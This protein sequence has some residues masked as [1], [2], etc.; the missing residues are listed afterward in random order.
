[1]AIAWGFLRWIKVSFFP[2]CFFGFGSCFSFTFC[3]FYLVMK[4]VRGSFCSWQLTEVYFAA[5]VLLVWMLSEIGL[6]FWWKWLPK[7][8]CLRFYGKEIMG[9]NR[10]WFFFL[11]SSMNAK[12]FTCIKHKE[13]PL[14]LSHS[15]CE[16]GLDSR[17]CQSDWDWES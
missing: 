8:Q 13:D 11:F 7:D 1:M 12:I 17:R 14:N 10:S 2:F 3:I 9:R 5:F 4:W 6:F 16:R 15:L